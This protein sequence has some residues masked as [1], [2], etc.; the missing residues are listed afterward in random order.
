MVDR[1]ANKVIGQLRVHAIVLGLADAVAGAF[2]AQRRDV[3]QRLAK[4][5]SGQQFLQLGGRLIGQRGTNFDTALGRRNLELPTRVVVAVAS[6]KD[7]PVRLQVVIGGV[8]IRAFQPHGAG[9][10][11]AAVDQV[12]Q[13]R[14]LESVVDLP[15]VFAFE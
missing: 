4:P 10:D 3:D 12:V 9:S 7:D 13:P 15:F 2:G 5:Q 1:G 6:A 11:I 14:H 8:V